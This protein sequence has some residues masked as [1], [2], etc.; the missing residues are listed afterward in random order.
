MYNK[1]KQHEYYL[2][3]REKLLTRQ[4]ELI[5]TEEYKRHIKEYRSREEVK[6]KRKAAN[7]KW[8][9]KNKEYFKEYHKIYRKT[10]KNKQYKLQYNNQKYIEDLSYRLSINF[11]HLIQHSLREG[12]QSIHWEKLVNYTLEDLKKH[13][14]NQFE[15]W[16]NWNNQGLTATSPRIT[17]QI[18]HIK[19]VNTFNITS[20]DSEEF[21]KC[22][23]LENLR[24]LDSYYNVRRPKDGSDIK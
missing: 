2:K 17:W 24:P 18:D 10:N 16:M 8:V 15:D 19:P 6:D 11:S 1:E 12:K 22:W 14:E 5:K 4:K 23:S 3:K 9:E 13:L 21:K 20:F 7:K